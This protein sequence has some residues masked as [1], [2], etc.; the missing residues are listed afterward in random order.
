LQGCGDLTESH[1]G[2]FEKLARNLEADFTSHLSE[3][4]P[5][6]PQ[7]TVQGAAVHRKKAGDC[8]DGTG[9]PEQFGTKNP[10]QIVGDGTKVM[11]QVRFV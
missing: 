2:V 8:V 6:H 4:K 3:R 5:F 9:A 1:I 7:M 11:A 10:A